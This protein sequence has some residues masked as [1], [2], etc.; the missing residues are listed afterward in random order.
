MDTIKIDHSKVLMIAHR[1]VS[2][3]EIENTCP[4]FIAAAVKSYYGIETDVHVTLDGKFII[5]HDDNIKRVTGI[6]MVIEENNYDNLKKISIR[7]K[8]NSTRSDL[9]FPDLEDYLRICKKYNK[10]S[11]LELKNT[12]T[13]NHIARLV[14]TVKNLDWF[15]KTTFISFSKENVITL[16][17]SYPD[18]DVLFLT[19]QATE[20]TLEFLLKYRIGLDIYYKSLSKEYVDLLHSKEIK[21][22]CWTVDEPKD[23]YALIDMGVDAITSNILE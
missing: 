7:E 9:V 18:A 11:I 1:G 15:F 22:Y 21:V 17:Q 3:L 4:A 16:K 13:Q 6:D 20:E 12:M 2:G 5:C 23:A 8:D 14:E 10:V 19:D